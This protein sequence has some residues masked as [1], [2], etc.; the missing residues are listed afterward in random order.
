MF[1]IC[2]TYI[3]LW[4]LLLV[5]IRVIA[6]CNVCAWIISC[7]LFWWNHVL[8]VFTLKLILYYLTLQHHQLNFSLFSKPS[9]TLNISVIP[10]Q[11]MSD[12]HY[13]VCLNTNSA[14][15]NVGKN[16]RSQTSKRNVN[17]TL[18]WPVIRCDLKLQGNILGGVCVNRN[19][20]LF[21][22]EQ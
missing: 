19:M 7:F 3:S 13:V 2:I 14:N 4:T 16:R 11:F 22:I 6:P 5:S 1:L 17:L 15:T 20:T 10:W 12:T 9:N 21:L 8:D 18:P